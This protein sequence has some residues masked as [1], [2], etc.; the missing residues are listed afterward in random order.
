MSYD[1]FL[2]HNSEDKPAVRRLR[3]QLVAR[4]IRP[5][6]DEQ[7]LLPGDNWVDRLAGQLGSVPAVAVI[8]GPHGLGPVQRL[9]ITQAIAL[10]AHRK[11]RLIPVLVES[12]P[13]TLDG[14]PFLS[15]FTWVDLAKPG[16]GELERLVLAI[17]SARGDGTSES[18]AAG[19]LPTPERKVEV[20][21][22]AHRSDRY[23]LL[24][25]ERQWNRISQLVELSA[26][27]ALLLP[28]PRG[29]GH[30]LFCKRLESS[31]PAG[32]QVV[33]VPSDVRW[34]PA[35]EA[36]AVAAWS[37]AL[38]DGQEMSRTDLVVFL[39]DLVRESS[40]VFV[41]PTV[42]I[43]LV[44]EERERDLARCLLEW[45]P[46]LFAADP[47]LSGADRA[48]RGCLLFVQPLAWTLPGSAARAQS[49]VESVTSSAPR[50]STEKLPALERIDMPTIET[51][52]RDLRGRL[53][54]DPELVLRVA[55]ALPTEQLFN[56]L[57][58]NLAG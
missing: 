35:V 3:D 10:L 6:L 40:L 7:D 18:A 28:G 8:I 37:R 44:D 2:C 16:Q 34:P 57:R 45:V 27:R 23:L 26:P 22:R 29:E 48:A 14:I 4:G 49:L 54:S 52:V 51:F 36:D 42:D 24:D 58:D 55:P 13:R 19:G 1:V 21:T 20:R 56:L 9:E 12:A 15:S 47:L 39:S 11:L 38:P 50:N 32:A 25:R 30:D 31:P 17:R 53:K 43:D 5:F 41:H 33:L 46:G